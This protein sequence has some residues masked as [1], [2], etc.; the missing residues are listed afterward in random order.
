MSSLKIFL[1]PS[2]A[3]ELKPSWNWMI[4]TETDERNL[5]PSTTFL[6]QKGETTTHI[7][8]AS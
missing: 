7:F 8:I 1:L 3:T 5:N 2:S 6:L 4:S